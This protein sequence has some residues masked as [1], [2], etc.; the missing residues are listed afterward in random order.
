M[1]SERKW[2][3]LSYVFVAVLAAWVLNRLLMTGVQIAHIRNPMVMGVMPT[4]MVLSFAAMAI[5]AY[6]YFRQEKVNT[7]SSEVVQEMKK[8]SWPP[9]KNT[10]ASTLVVLVAVIIAAGILGFY[11]FICAKIIGGIL[12]I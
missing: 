1:G 3:L 8:V 11:D 2:I 5:A 4:T 10:Y 7:F 6:F 9:R 12:G